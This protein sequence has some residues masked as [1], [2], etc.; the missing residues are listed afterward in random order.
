[1]ISEAA[2]DLF[3]RALILEPGFPFSELVIKVRNL[4]E[5]FFFQSQIKVF[6]FFLISPTSK[7]KIQFT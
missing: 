5:F 1:M 3:L 6:L 4:T 2:S 7:K